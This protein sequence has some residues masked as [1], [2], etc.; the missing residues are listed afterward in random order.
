MGDIPV[1]VEVSAKEKG[2]AVDVLA[3]AFHD[4]PV[5]RYILGHDNPAY[6]D[7]LR[8]LVNFFCEVRL[9]MGGPPL[10]LRDGKK[11]LAAALV[12]PPVSGPFTAEL[13]EMLDNL[14]D[15][16]GSQAMSRLEAYED[17]CERMQ[18]E[19]PHYY[20]GM[21][22]V[23]PDLRGKGY[24]RMLI[25]HLHQKVDHDPQAGGICLNTENPNNVPM[26]RHLGYVVIGEEDLGP[27]HTWCMYRPS[28]E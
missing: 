23:L 6:E 12:D 20:L 5:F 26:Y 3:A 11:P 4:Y 22:G 17:M 19:Q 13:R 18:P 27:L 14:I 16:V 8:M 15:I 1:V 28:S 2:Q 25:E 21:I 7:K 10:V 9:Q 24:A